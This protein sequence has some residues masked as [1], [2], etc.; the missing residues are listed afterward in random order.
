MPWTRMELKNNLIINIA[1]VSS[2]SG[3]T[4]SRS[5]FN[6][7]TEG[8]KSMIKWEAYNKYVG[9]IWW[10]AP[11][12]CWF[13]IQIQISPALNNADNKKF[14]IPSQNIS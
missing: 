3:V 5:S 13:L 8:N 4:L 2:C 1:I 6:Q 12:I 9:K 7:K 14:S 10:D 11:I